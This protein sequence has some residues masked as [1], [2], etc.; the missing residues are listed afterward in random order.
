MFNLSG[1]LPKKMNNLLSRFQP[2]WAVWTSFLAGTYLSNVL[3]LL[4]LS[5]LPSSPPRHTL[6]T[7]FNVFTIYLTQSVTRKIS[8][9]FALLC[10]LLLSYRLQGKMWLL[11]ES[12]LKLINGSLQILKVKRN[13]KSH[14][15]GMWSAV[16]IFDKLEPRPFRK[17]IPDL[18]HG[19]K[20]P[21]LCF[22]SRPAEIWLYAA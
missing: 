3:P 9:R 6:S 10:G 21:L 15:C 22:Q 13:Q 17:H 11:L 2:G 7:Q 16:L 8:I 19:V 20:R 5:I 1:S 14:H 4:P 12:G 18:F